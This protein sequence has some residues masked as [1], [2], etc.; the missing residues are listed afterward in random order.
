MSTKLRTILRY[1]GTCDGNMEEGSLRAD[2]NV[3]VRK[4]GDAARHAL[5]DQ[6]RQF[7]P[8]HRAGGRLRGAPPDRHPR[9]RRQDRSGDAPVTIPARARP[10]RC[11][12]R[13]RRTTIATSPI[14]ICCRSNSSRPGSMSSSVAFAGTAGREEGA[15]HRAQYGLSPYD[16]GVLVARA[17]VRRLFRGDVA[18][19]RDAK[20]RRQLGD[21]RIVR[22]P[23][24]GGPEHRR[25]SPVS[26]AQ[27]GA[28]RRSDRRRNASPARSPRTC[29]RSSGR[30]GGDPRDDRR[31][32]RPEAGDRHRRDREGGRRDHR[33]QSG[34]GRAGARQ[35]RRCS[36]GSSVR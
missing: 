20:A 11:A 15:L 23:Q 6:E 19:G 7:D 33:R 16:A 1:L 31:S 18:K 26:A 36:A 35:S 28:H 2:V 9:R 30:E 12:R 10:A 21:Q 22:P 17:R 14:P 5:R 34:Q 4:P 27:I 25:P 8:L 3:S 13:K 24:Q 32:A 29:S